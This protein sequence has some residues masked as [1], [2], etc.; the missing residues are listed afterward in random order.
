MA[1]EIRVNS[2][3]NRSG[4]G[5]ISFGSYGVEIAGITTIEKLTVSTGTEANFSG[6][7]TATQFNGTQANFSGVVTATA[8]Y[9]D[10]SNLTNVG[11][12][13]SLGD[14]NDVVTN[15][16]GVGTDQLLVW[17]NDFN[18]WERGYA[19]T[20]PTMSS[21]TVAEDSSNDEDRFA[22]QDFTVTVNMSENGHPASSKSVKLSISDSSSIVSRP[23]SSE[24]SSVDTSY[25]YTDEWTLGTLAAGSHQKLYWEPSR[26]FF[27][28]WAN[29][30]YGN[31]GIHYSYDGL[32]W[33]AVNTNSVGAIYG[34]AYNPNTGEFLVNEWQRV[35]KTKDF[36]NW[37]QIATLNNNGRNEVY[38]RIEWFPALNRYFTI[39]GGYL[40]GGSIAYSSDGVSWSQQG[41]TSSQTLQRLV[42][43][44][45]TNTMVCLAAGNHSG[46][47]QASYTTNPNGSPPS[48]SNTW[49]ASGV[50]MVLNCVYAGGGFAQWYWWAYNNTVRKGAPTS[51]ANGASY[52]TVKTFASSDIGPAS[53]DI[54]YIPQLDILV[55]SGYD[56]A[57]LGR[58]W[59]CTPADDTSW[60]E[61][62]VQPVSD[63]ARYGWVDI[64]YS[65][66]LGRYVMIAQNTTNSNTSI[67]VATSDTLGLSTTRTRITFADSTGL[68]NFRHSEIVTE[69][70]GSAV[71]AMH[72]TTS[73]TMVLY[74]TTGTFNSGLTVYGEEK[75]ASTVYA[76]FGSTGIVTSFVEYDPGYTP[77]TGDGPYT[78]E[79]PGA[80]TNG[81]D[82]DTKFG[83]SSAIT[84]SATATN[85]LGT[86]SQTSTAVTP[87]STRTASSFTWNANTDAYTNTTTAANRIIDVH[88]RMRRCLVTDN[89][90]VTYL[91]ADDSTKLA[92]DWLRI[93]E[94]TQLSTARTGTHGSETA[95]TPLRSGVSTWSAGTYRR[96]SR[97][98]HNSS[99][100]ECIV[101]ST[102]ATPAAGSSASTLDGTAG[103]VMVEIPL[104]SV[105]HTRSASGS[106]NEHGFYLVRGIK[107]DDSYE[108]HP[109]FV[110]SDGSYRPYLYIGAYLGSGTS[111]KNSVSGQT[112]ASSYTRASARAEAQS[113]GDGWRLMSIYQYNVLQWLLITEYQNMDSQEVLGNGSSEGSSGT[114]TT[115]LSNSRGNRSQNAHTGG[116]SSTDYVSYR[117]VE[118]IFGRGHQWADGANITSG[119]NLYVTDNPLYMIDDTTENFTLYGTIGGSDG[120]YLRD[121]SAGVLFISSS[122]TGG[123][124]TTYV[125]DA[126]SVSTGD[127][128]MRVGGA[129][130]DAAAAGIMRAN[131]DSDSSNVGANRVS[132]ITFASESL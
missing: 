26:D 96:G 3:S 95:N 46:Y 25:S 15:N 54:Q 9:G 7:V 42:Y 90:L 113:R 30:S 36:V 127:R 21:V 94:H 58:M 111:G 47:A 88:S 75:N 100:W 117:G 115:G 23:V 2:I 44:E 51:G 86:A 45:D 99:L 105:K 123:S 70:D 128:V 13:A 72:T 122:T 31:N 98:I 84:V 11:A 87:A 107:T 79:F 19:N 50:D 119:T 77:M 14:L 63:T 17:N 130:G 109:A 131:Y 40:N 81:L 60:T 121:I 66:K 1:S 82:L 114:A 37:T 49:V 93:C 16:V 89:G 28:T 92:G 129:S 91:D 62:Q 80:D 53:G 18:R 61:I 22:N 116:G 6:V 76:K 56:N 125:A 68:S 43:S 29:G 69:S 108:V 55:V 65:S 10:A 52:T 33:N 74:N 106:Y 97:V 27:W 38:S 39:Q 4:L 73:N 103:Q 83:L 64:E 112:N 59:Y 132:R 120:G 5:T 102:T 8:F 35:H 104:F 32:S 85:K 71:G 20:L 34:A 67:C 124:S 57:G 118:N 48:W 41:G 126:L 12:A 24:I 101:D 78:F 110:R